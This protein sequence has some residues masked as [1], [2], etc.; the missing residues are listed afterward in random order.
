M[1]FFNIIITLCVGLVMAGG[2]ALT[3]KH[4]MAETGGDVVIASPAQFLNNVA[5]Q[6]AALPKWDD[7]NWKGLTYHEPGYYKKKA[8]E[9][10]KQAASKQPASKQTAAR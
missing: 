9:A 6:R 7:K 8:E 2:A 3:Y 5:A 10:A 4:R 1:R